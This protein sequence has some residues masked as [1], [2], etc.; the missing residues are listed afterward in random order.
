MVLCIAILAKINEQINFLNLV[1]QPSPPQIKSVLLPIVISEVQKIDKNN[2]NIMEE[3][4]CAH[5]TEHTIKHSIYKAKDIQKCILKAKYKVK[6]KTGIVRGE[7]KEE[8]VCA[9]HFS[10]IKRKSEGLK[11]RL[12]F[13]SDL[14]FELL[15]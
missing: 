4:K 3:Y 7:Y 15:Q 6:Y 10:S 14:T 13:D 12:D 2:N 8:I 9:R 5:Y 1:N 11:K